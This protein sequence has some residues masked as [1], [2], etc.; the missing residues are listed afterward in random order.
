[1]S[2]KA[3]LVEYAHRLGFDHVGVA[4]AGPADPGGNLARWLEAGRHGEMAYMA[5]RVAERLD[6]RA[7]LPGARSVVALSTYYRHDRPAP[8]PGLRGR[9]SRYAWARDYHRVVGRRL[10][11]LRRWLQEAAPGAR[12]YAEVDTGP[13]LEKVWAERAGLGWIGKHGNLLTRRRSSWILLATLVTDLDL[14]PD[15]PHPE[16][17]GSCDRCIRACPTQAIVA[18]GIVDARLCIS[19]HTIEHRGPIP[20]SLRA[21]HGTWLFG[22][23]DCQEVCP[24]NKFAR[25]PGDTAFAPRPEQADPELR[26]VLA[27]DEA[28]FR[29]RYEGTPLMRA[30]RAGLARSAAVVLGNLG[31]GEAVPALARAL[32]SDPSPVVRG[33]AAWALGRIGGGSARAAL[34]AAAGAE[35]DLAVRDEIDAA[36]EALAGR[37]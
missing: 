11:K 10:R 14:Q 15:R 23:D 9:V 35:R 5:R 20:D 28:A 26:D 7:L 33:H 32:A 24:W 34:Q 3:R 30:G 1:M 8:A 16:H 13:V 31:A 12:V 21:R 2:V 22:C 25:E 27:L 29:A 19:H 37:S 6:P 36:L 17:C 18:P 4:P